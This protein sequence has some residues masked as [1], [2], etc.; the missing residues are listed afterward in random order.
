M[1]VEG[2]WDR[3]NTPL[4][5]RDKRLLAAAA[6]IGAIAVTIL[7]VVYLTRSSSASGEG[8]LVANVPSTMGGAQLRICGDAAHAFCRSHAGDTTIAAACRRQGFAP[9][10]V[11]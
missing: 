5:R 2:Q 11:P 7:A 1:P 3:S 10:L 8:C 6:V 4:S 9:D